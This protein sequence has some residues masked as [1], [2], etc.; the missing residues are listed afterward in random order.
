MEGTSATRW[1]SPW[2][3]SKV[4]IPNEATWSLRP[5]VFQT[6]RYHVLLLPL[7]APLFQHPFSLL[8]F[9]TNRTGQHKHLPFQEFLRLTGVLPPTFA[10]SLIFR[11]LSIFCYMTLKSTTVGNGILK[12]MGHVCSDSPKSHHRSRI[13]L[14]SLSWG[15]WIPI[16][17]LRLDFLQCWFTK[18]QPNANIF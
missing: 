11:I 17:S 8:D 10:T 6:N 16:E 4:K 12:T 9:F 5:T 2:L 13:V 18:G 7:S 14:K 15:A 3:H 1:C